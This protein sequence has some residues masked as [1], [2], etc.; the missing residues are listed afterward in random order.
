LWSFASSINLSTASGSSGSGFPTAISGRTL[1][2][3]AAKSAPLSENPESAQVKVETYTEFAVPS[4]H[5][6]S[7][8]Q[9]VRHHSIQL[10]LSRRRIDGPGWLP[11]WARQD[12][13]GWIGAPQLV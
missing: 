9:L 6:Y 4:S 10:G 5:A 8:I 7:L 12:G 13:S 11:F 3:C 1:V 2:R